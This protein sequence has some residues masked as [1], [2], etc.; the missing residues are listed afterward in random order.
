[1]KLS[2]FDFA[3]P[4]ERIARFPAE[5][6]DGS[7]LMRLDRR[8][9]SVSHHRFD[10]LPGLLADRDFLV[11]NDS[12][13]IPAR[14]LGAI[15]GRAA[16]MLV[17]GDLGDGRLEVLCRPAA[18]FRLG[19]V[20]SG[21]GGL[22]GEVLAGGQR[23][24]RVLRFDRSCDEVLAHGYAPLPPYIQRRGEEAVARRGF[25]L[26]RYQTVYAR[27][28]GSI[29]APTAG[30]HFSPEVLA[31]L[32]RERPVL[33][34]TLTVGE[35]TFQAITAEEIE[36]HRMGSE[37]VRIPSATA[38]RIAALKG[39]G[40]RLLAVGTTTVRALESYALLPEPRDD[41]HSE[42][43]IRPGFRFLLVDALLTNFH[44]PKSTLFILV[45]AFAGLERLQKAYREAIEEKY[46]FFSYGDAMLII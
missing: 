41:F 6:R 9:G 22:R 1:M 46:R 12:R 29:A 44:L 33:R 24:R 2:D 31:R 19:A 45:A 11:V 43:F 3:L 14:L 34:I 13:V 8:R 17:I 40:G 20:F 25:D 7:R 27:Q 32:R 28:P 4:R 36:R 39:A 23:G 15:G 37:H 38:G 10:E 26:E 35:A 5:R 21:E 16:E 30:L 42:L 18:R